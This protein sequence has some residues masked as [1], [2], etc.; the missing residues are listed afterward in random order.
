MQVP[1]EMR[2]FHLLWPSPEIM[3]PPAT[4]R[5][6]VFFEP[7]TAK[8]NPMAELF[9]KTIPGQAGLDFRSIF[10]GMDIWQLGTA[11]ELGK[12]RMSTQNFY[13]G[14]ESAVSGAA[15]NDYV[16]RAGTSAD[17]FLADIQQVID[18][19][20]G[21]FNQNCP[22]DDPITAEA[23]LHRASAQTCAGC[24]APE[25]FIGPERKLGCGMT[26]PTTLGEVHIDEKGGLSPALTEAFL[27]R[28]ADVL[29][30]YL[31]ACD[32]G[33]VYGNLEPSNGKGIPK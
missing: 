12:V 7:V 1:W 24:H 17:G 13:N 19:N 15:S 4:N 30:T 32:I 3:A 2:V 9:D 21:V 10:S 5:P 29:Q 28:R 26:F 16:S 14:G 20:P 25:K 8:N 22:P 33:A 27:P 6:P 11:T 31:Q 23:I 18:T